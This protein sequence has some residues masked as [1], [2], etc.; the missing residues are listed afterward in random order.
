MS[1]I[2]VSLAALSV[3]PRLWREGR[4]LHART[5][6]VHRALCGFAYGRKLK[7]DPVART[8]SLSVRR[9]WALNSTR[10]V[11]FE[12]I[13]A[14]EYR[15]ADLPTAFGVTLR[16]LQATNRMNWYEVSLAL[17]G[18]A[19]PLVMFR[20]AGEGAEW[21]GWGGAVLGDSLIDVQGTQE[22]ESREFVHVLR[23]MLN[24]PVRSRAERMVAAA[25]AGRL[26]PCPN[27]ARQIAETAPRCTYCGRR[28]V[29]GDVER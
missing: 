13:A 21:T 26:R 20:F 16:G 19:E 28:F 29:V 17:R 7:V 3:S 25:F 2:S 8:I 23:I 15:Y 5:R 27:C 22:V 9:W 10:V 18:C 6:W 12:E 4:T 1:V 14:L 11:S 24:V